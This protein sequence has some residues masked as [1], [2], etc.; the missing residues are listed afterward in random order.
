MSRI[1]QSYP[2]MLAVVHPTPPALYEFRCLHPIT[3][4]IRSPPTQRLIPAYTENHLL[5]EV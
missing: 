3:G 1:S 2:M 4:T 5:L